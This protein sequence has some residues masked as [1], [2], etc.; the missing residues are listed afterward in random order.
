MARTKRSAQLSAG[1]KPKTASPEYVPDDYELVDN[2]PPA[3]QIQTPAT[4]TPPSGKRRVREDANPT[5]LPAKKKSRNT[6]LSA[7]TSAEVVGDSDDEDDDSSS[8]AH[9]VSEATDYADADIEEDDTETPKASK[10]M[11]KK[12]AANLK[13]QLGGKLGVNSSEEPGQYSVAGVPPAPII[14][15]PSSAF[16]LENKLEWASSYVDGN[17]KTHL[18]VKARSADDPLLANKDILDPYMVKNGHYKNLPNANKLR[19]PAMNEKHNEFTSGA[20]TSQVP[21][22]SVETWE[23]FEIDQ[24]YIVSLHR[25]KHQAN[26]A[27]ASTVDVTD[28]SLKETWSNAGPGSAYIACDKANGRPV[29]FI[30]VGAV[31]ESFLMVGRNVG[32][33]GKAPC[34]KGLLILGHRCEHERLS[35]MFATLWQA[36]DIVVPIQ[37]RHITLQTRNRPNNPASSSVP[38]TP[39]KIEGTIKIGKMEIK[40]YKSRDGN[41]SSSKAAFGS[42]KTYIDWSDKV[43]V[44]DGRNQGFDPNDIAGSLVRLPEY[45]SSDGEVPEGTGVAVGYTAT[46]SKFLSVWKL[47]FNIMWVVVIAD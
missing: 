3:T 28:L 40:T 36:E 13:T 5:P 35:C 34:A 23:C 39:Q 41:G 6:A 26:F 20:L 8:T 22:L 31:M 27:N 21:G 45:K 44:Y 32:Y 15:L 7:K 43:P 18:F 11:G 19:L 1:S 9:S 24:A 37:R 12:R 10:I 16:T 42:N 30:L 47:T 2:P 14:T 38:S 29:T 25:F 33:E 46:T 17:G 4:P